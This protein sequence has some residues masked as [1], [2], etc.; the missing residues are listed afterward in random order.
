MNFETVNTWKMRAKAHAMGRRN[1]GGSA[2]FNPFRHISYGTPKRANTMDAAEQGKAPREAV[3]GQ[4]NPTTSAPGRLLTPIQQSAR[5]SKELDGSPEQTEIYN[6]QAPTL[7][8]DTDGASIRQ[9]TTQEIT[10][11]PQT[12]NTIKEA[13]EED[14][15]KKRRDE[16]GFFKHI[17][18]TTPF[19]VRNQIQR[20]FFGSPINILALAAPAGIALY[21]IGYDGKVVFAV[22]FIAIVPLA[23]MLS[24]ATEEIAMRTGEVLGGLI[25]ASFGNAVELIVAIIALTQNK[26]KVVQTSL[27]G[28]ILSNLLL[29]LG[30]CFFCGGINR[31][32][33]FFN[34]TV[35]Q[36]AASLLALAVGS[37]IVPTVFAHT[38]D[39]NSG[40]IIL[41]T[42]A[43]PSLSHGVAIILLIVY[44]SYL[45]FQMKTHVTMFNEQ[46]QKVAGKPLFKKSLPENAIASGIARVGA[47]VAMD[48]RS[49]NGE[50]N[51]IMK[52]PEIEEEEEEGPQLSFAVAFA[53][54]IGATVI[55]A[56]CAEGMVNGIEAITSTGAV[57]E[58][59]VGLIL[60]PIVG[61]A[62]EHA[63]AVT[64]AIKDKMDLAIGVAIGSSMQVALLLIPLLV[65][66]GWGMGNQDMTLAF[67]TFQVIVLFV[68]VLLVNYLIGDGKSHWL[69]GLILT[70]LYAIIAT[71]A[72][73]Y[74]TIP[75]GESG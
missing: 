35:A 28:S 61:N 59:F 17:E 42:D 36:T 5:N 25:N 38:D 64:V 1:S 32:E 52:D 22:N 24:N 15:S 75:E 11:K 31:K 10:S 18:P 4:L 74:P 26:I 50:S 56:L 66:I 37:L 19:T 14:K 27:V 9:R 21:F 73:F 71:C 70:C 72:W 62:C 29:V 67:D 40:S 8:N 69:E 16:G 23:A 60:L 34:T 41:P 63:T 12:P 3:P 43:V 51:K 2:R 54:L 57:S 6:S 33:Q 46:S 39:L 55:I 53:T 30:F 20:V 48:I 13:A 49:E 44:A 58:E 65:I 45:F 68:S 47:G 7:P